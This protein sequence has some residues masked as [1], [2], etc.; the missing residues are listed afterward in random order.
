MALTGFGTLSPPR[1]HAHDASTKEIIAPCG[2]SSELA[3]QRLV[4]M[5]PALIGTIVMVVRDYSSLRAEL[6][7]RLPGSHW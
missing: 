5:T 7:P 2:V 6:D 4:S 1:L 3:L